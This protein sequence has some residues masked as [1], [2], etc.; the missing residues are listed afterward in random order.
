QINFG[1]PYP[2][3]F[4]ADMQTTEGTEESYLRYDRRTDTGVQ[5]RVEEGPFDNSDLH[6]N[7]AVGYLAWNTSTPAGGTQSNTLRVDTSAPSFGAVSITRTGGEP[8]LSDGDTFEISAE[9]TDDG[10]VESVTADVSAL[11]A[12]RVTLTGSGDTYNGTVTVGEAPSTTR[13]VII[14]ASDTLG[15]RANVTAIAGPQASWTHTVNGTER[16]ATSTRVV[17]SAT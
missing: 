10:G 12:E 1:D 5:V 17:M 6:V 13:S 8:P 2:G 15:Q 3:G 7:E 16:P 11:D 9:V 4:I 14:T